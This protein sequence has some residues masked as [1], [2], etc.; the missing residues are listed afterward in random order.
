MRPET[1]ARK[2]RRC[3]IRRGR[4]EGG[5]AFAIVT[6]RGG[7]LRAGLLFHDALPEN[8]QAE[9]HLTRFADA[10][11]HGAVEV[12]DQGCDLGTVKVFA[13]EQIEDVDGGL[14][15]VVPER[16]SFGEAEIERRERVVLAAE[17]TLRNDGIG[18][19]GRA[20]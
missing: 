12:E 16:E 15:F 1:T 9:M 14:D 11:L 8:A 2:R 7:R 19:A 3:A 4:G 6:T 13:V 20:V 5:E 17:V 18:E 10:A